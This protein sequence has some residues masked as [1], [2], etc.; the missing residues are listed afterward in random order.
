[1]SITAFDIV[2]TGPYLDKIFNLKPS[3]PVNSNFET[4]G[5]ESLYVL[6][7]L[8]TFLLVFVFLLIEFIVS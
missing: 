7:N 1:M 3:E 8:G 2:E 6:H 5:F 4:V